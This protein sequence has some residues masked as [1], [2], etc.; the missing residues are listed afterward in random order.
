MNIISLKKCLTLPVE[1][2]Y[3]PGDCYETDNG[4]I[5]YY[6]DNDAKVLGVAH[7]D[8]VGDTEVYL[9]NA[10]L[11]CMQLDDRLGV[12]VLCN[13]LPRIGI[14]LDILLT[15]Q[16]ERAQSTARHFYPEKKYNWVVEFDRAGTD[17]VFYQY[18]EWE[19]L[20]KKEGWRTSYGSF[21]DICWLDHLGVMCANVGVGYHFQHS[22]NCCANLND[23]VRQAKRFARFWD[24]YKDEPFLYEEK[25]D[26]IYNKYGDNHIGSF[27]SQYEWVKANGEWVRSSEIDLDETKTNDDVIDI[28]ENDL[29]VVEEEDNDRW[30]GFVP[31]GRS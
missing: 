25:D 8:T 3:W 24:T 23:T 22:K 14:N 17:V 15:D 1:S 16:E 13:L 19:D 21:S 20:W 18:D 29:W 10:T 4:E 26:N 11:Q 28:D 12:W 6:Q 30:N 9:T 2:R 27:A 7:L 5:F 31:Y